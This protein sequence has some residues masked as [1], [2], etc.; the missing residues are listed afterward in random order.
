[1]L[2]VQEVQQGLRSLSQLTDIVPA[3]NIYA[4]TLPLEVTKQAVE[5]VHPV[6]LVTSIR[7]LY[8]KFASNHA[9]G[10]YRT[11]QIQG[12]FDP[13][14]TRADKVRRLI[15]TACEAIGYYNSYDADF[16]M[17]PDTSEFY[18][19]TQYTKNSHNEDNG[20]S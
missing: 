5:P 13:A 20:L 4:F 1:M 15:N 18:F 6:L 3:E 17:D 14:D 16:D 11:V 19:T 8:N 7:G 9:Y 2:Q 10:A 12:W